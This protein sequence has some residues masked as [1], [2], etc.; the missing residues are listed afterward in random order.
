MVKCCAV[1]PLSG[2]IGSAH[3]KKRYMCDLRTSDFAP[4][5]FF[6]LM[7]QKHVRVY[8][9]EGVFILGGGFFWAVFDNFMLNFVAAF[10]FEGTKFKLMTGFSVQG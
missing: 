10:F 7:P 6:G 9:A 5:T 3:H 1:A 8:F 4:L 2:E